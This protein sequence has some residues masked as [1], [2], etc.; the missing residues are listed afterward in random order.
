MKISFEIP[1]NAPMEKVWAR[2]IDLSNYPEWN[3]LIPTAEGT[4]GPEATLRLSISPMGLNRRA[5][6]ALVTG[7]IAPKYFSFEDDH[8][9]GSWF[10]REELVFRMKPRDG[11]VQFHAEAFVTG[12]SLRFRRDS[13]EGAFRRSLLRVCENIKE[14]A[15]ANPS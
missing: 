10:Y 12:L 7:F 11:G 13:V 3:P 2:L 14:W 8:R 5:V 9:F 6:S 15:E 1:I 4:P